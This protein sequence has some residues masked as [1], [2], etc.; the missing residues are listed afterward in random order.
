LRDES[1][2]KCAGLALYCSGLGNGTTEQIL[3][4]RYKQGEVNLEWVARL[5]VNASYLFEL[6]H[7]WWKAFR[8]VG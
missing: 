3:S 7:D 2:D 5:D 8:A 4:S 1:S 6:T